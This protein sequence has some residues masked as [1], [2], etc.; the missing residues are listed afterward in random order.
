MESLPPLQAL[1]KEVLECNVC[2]SFLPYG[3]RPVVQISETSRIVIVG[4]APVR[5]V[6]ETGIP[7]NDRSGDRLRKWLNASKEEFYDPSLFALL[8]MGFCYPGIGKSGDLPPRP[9]CAPLWHN[10]LTRKLD[11]VKLT[12]LCGQYAQKFYL[13]DRFRRSLTETIKTYE[14]LLPEFLPLPHPSPRNIAWFK[15]NAWFEKELIPI[16]RNCVKRILTS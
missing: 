15:A 6:H 11:N 10:L 5:I 4:Q 1:I 12:L 16:L 14:D 9:E 2:A 8:P 3:P 7:W 13:Q